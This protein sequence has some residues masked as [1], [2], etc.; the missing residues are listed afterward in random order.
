ML[1]PNHHTQHLASQ[2]YD[3]RLDHAARI[4]MVQRERK[5][6]S[7]PM[8]REGHRLLTVRRLAAAGIAGVV[9][10]AALA[11]GGAA[12]ASAAPNHAQGGGAAHIR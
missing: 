10:T 7:Q 4:R 8:N 6:E 12:T 5:D 1:G 2:S 3:A 9:L 11:A